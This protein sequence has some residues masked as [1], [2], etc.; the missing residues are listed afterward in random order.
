MTA[1]ATK[2]SGRGHGDKLD[3]R[4]EHAITALLTETTME[5]AAKACGVS[6]STLGRWLQLE[7]FQAA[8][9]S[10][11]RAVTDAAIARLQQVAAEAVA[12]LERNLTC[13]VPTVE[14]QAARSVLELA[15]RDAD[16]AELESRLQALEKDL[17]EPR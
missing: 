7:A 11:R 15:L 8:Y 1:G 3:R 5:A 6:R 16:T 10:A 12:A 2:S 17:E 9:R 13:H 4:Q 14:V